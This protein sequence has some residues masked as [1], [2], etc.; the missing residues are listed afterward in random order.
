MTTRFDRLERR[1]F[2]VRTEV[3][4][5]ATRAEA[6]RFGGP[7][8]VTR[9]VALRIVG[10]RVQGVCCGAIAQ[11]ISAGDVSPAGRTARQ[12]STVRR[13]CESIGL[14]KVVT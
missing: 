5:A 14:G 11:L 10:M 3:A 7:C 4:F 9:V 13:D 1:L 8:R 2:A 6:V 12:R